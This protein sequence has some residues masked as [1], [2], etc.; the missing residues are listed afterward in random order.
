MFA[1]EI[2]PGLEFGAGVVVGE[3]AFKSVEADV[4]EV[5]GDGEVHGH[6]EGGEGDVG[7]SVFAEEVEGF[8]VFI[9]GGWRNSTA[10][11]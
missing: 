1:A 9:P 6:V 2:G 8:W 11:R 4:N 10:W 7:G 5:G 3:A